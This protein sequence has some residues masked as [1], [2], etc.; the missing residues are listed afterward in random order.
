MKI[1]IIDLVKDYGKFRALDGVSLTINQGMFGLLGPNGAGKTTLMRVITT[2]MP[3]TSGQVSVGGIDVMRDP[4]FVRKNLGYIPQDFGFYKS[5]NAYDLLDYIGTMK[6]LTRAER[7]K[8]VKTLLEQVNLTKDAKRRVGGYSGGMK[9]RLGIAQ[10]LLGDPQLIIV[11]EP[12][13]GLDPEERIRFRNLLTRLSGERTVLLSTHIVGDIEA[14]CSAVAVL[15]RGRVI[16]NGTPETLTRHANGLM[17]QV[18]I[19]PHEYEQVES[20]YRVTATRTANGRMQVRVLS[21]ENPLGRGIPVES[22]LE[23][24]YMAVITATDKE[25]HHA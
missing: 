15:N 24:G 25:A 11:D 6:G 18:E 12:T 9:Q 4:G 21:P 14:S 10:A 17:W 1:E 5:L 3:V 22:E 16:F 23:E 2:L 20:R 13:A 7:Q 19:E 8:Q